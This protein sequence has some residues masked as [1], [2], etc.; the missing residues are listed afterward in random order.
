MIG[1][2]SRREIWRRLQEMMPSR[3]QAGAYFHGLLHGQKHY[4][5]DSCYCR[6]QSDLSW[7]PSSQQRAEEH[8]EFDVGTQRL[9]TFFA[10][11]SREKL[12]FFA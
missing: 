12:T 10:I 6:R 4:D 8:A 11:K 9:E 3:R 7:T 5:L 1:S 2:S